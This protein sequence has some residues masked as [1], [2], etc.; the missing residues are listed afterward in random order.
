MYILL[1]RELFER[2]IHLK[3][4]PKNMK[5][6]YKKYLQFEID[7]GSQ[8]LANAVVEKARAFVESSSS[9]QHL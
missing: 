5:F 1:C 7:H 4:S 6:F 8:A 3:V 2:V 9:Y